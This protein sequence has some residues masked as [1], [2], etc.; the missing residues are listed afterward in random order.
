MEEEKTLNSMK[1]QRG[2]L[3][4][5]DQITVLHQKMIENRASYRQKLQSSQ[6]AQH[7]QA[8]LVQKLQ[9]KVLQYRNWCKELEKRLES[10]SDSHPHLRDHKVEQNL[11][12][13]LVHLEEEQQRCENLGRVN[14]LLRKHLDKANEVNGALQEDIN[15]LT[16]DWTRAKIELEHKESDWHKERELFEHY[17][18]SEHDRILGIWRQVVTL[19][20][21]FLEMKTATD[22]DLSELKADQVRLYGSILI[23]CFHV[24]SDAQFWETKHLED[25]ILRCQLQERR[26]LGIKLEKI[27]MEK[28]KCQQAKAIVALHVKEDFSKEDLQSR[29]LELTALLDESHKQN[30]EKEK[31][32]KALRETVEMLK[33]NNLKIN[34]DQ[35]PSKDISEEIF[36]LQHV[37]TEITQAL[38][39]ENNATIGI[40]QVEKY[41]D[42]CG[43]VEL[44]TGDSDG[45]LLLLR[46]V[47]ARRRN[48]V[49]QLRQQLLESQDSATALGKQQKQQE[50]QCSFLR[51]RLEQLEGERDTYA[52][53]LQ[54]LQSV[55]ETYRS[56]HETLDKSRMELQQQL[57][58]LEQEA[59]HLRQSNTELQLKGDMADGEKEEKQEE[60][61][62]LMREREYIQEDQNALEEKHS[63]LKNELIAMRESLEK[64]HLDG[65]L[66]KQEKYELALALEQAEESL[67]KLTGVHNRLK[68]ET[69]NLHD[70]VTKM[71]AL[72]EALALDKVSLNQL[73]LKLEQENQALLD[74]VDHMER[75]GASLQKQL[76]Q[77]ER[78]NEELSAEKF[79]LE[80]LLHKA[81]ELQ[82]SLQNE[83]R[84]LT[85]EKEEAN[86]KLSQVHHQN[87]IYHT[88]LEQANQELIHT[89]EML[90]KTSREKES[91]MREKT[92]LEVRL[93]VVERDRLTLT[94]QVSKFR[95]G[96]DLLESNFF[97]TQQQLSQLE[98]T[99]DQ[100]EMKIQTINQAKEVVQGEVKCLRA[101]LE[102]AKSK[103]EQEKEEKAQQLSQ[104]EQKYQET[105]RRC[106]TVH[107]EEMDT[108]SKKLGNE[109]ER[110]QIELEH[111]GKEKEEIE[112]V[113]ERKLLEL[114][115]KITEIQTHMEDELIKAE[116]A[117]QEA[118]LEKDNEKKLLREEI[119]QANEKLA[120]TSQ[121]L[122][123]LHQEMKKLEKRE[124]NKVQ[125]LEA[126][127]KDTTNTMKTL[128]IKQNEE[129]K[130][131]KEEINLLLNQ[132]NSLQNQIQELEFQLLAAKDSCKLFNQEAEQ[133]LREK[134]ELSERKEL[135]VSQLQKVLETERKQKEELEQRNTELTAMLQSQWE[136]EKHLNNK[137]LRKKEE[138]EHQ[139]TTVQALERKQSQWEKVELQNSELQRQWEEAKS[140]IKLLQSQK[141]D[142]ELQNRNLRQQKEEV[143]LKNAKLKAVLQRQQEEAEHESALLQSHWEEAQK[144]CSEL[145][146]WKEKVEYQNAEFQALLH[147]R[148][149]EMESKDT[150]MKKEQNQNLELKA[151]L[152]TLEHERASLILSLEEKEFR[153]KKLQE[154]DDAHQDEITKLNSALQQ[155]EKMLAEH[156]QEVQELISQMESLKQMM[157]QKEAT[158]IAHGEQLTQD[159]EVSHANEQHAKDTIQKLE[160][161]VSQLRLSLCSTESRAEALASECQRVCSVHWEA[162]AQLIKLHSVLHYMLCNSP[163]PKL[164]GQGD[165]NILSTSFLNREQD[166]M[167][168]LAFSQPKDCSTELTAERVAEA[169]QDWRQDLW[170]AHLQLDEARKNSEKLKQELSEKETERIRINAKAE[171][172]E[173]WL[174]QCQEEKCVAEGRRSSLESALKLEVIAF[175]EENVILH[176]KVTSL[177]TKLEKTEKQ[178]KGLANER[179]TLQMTKEKLTQELQLLQESVK[180]SEHRASAMEKM[181]ESLKQELQTAL[182][183]LR[184]KHEEIETHQERFVALQKEVE[185]GK[186]LQEIV[187]QLNLTLEKRNEE[188]KDQLQQ[189][190]DL[191]NHKEKQ[192]AALE[193]LTKNLEHRS[194]EIDSQ[195]MQIEEMT[196]QDKMQKA[197][198][199]KLNLDLEETVQTLKSQQEKLQKLQELSEGQKTIIESLSLNLEEKIKEAKIKEEKIQIIEH[200]E[201][202][203][204]GTLLKDLDDLKIKMNEKGWEL[205]SQKKLLQEWE[206]QG[207]KREK[208]LCTSLE[209]MKAIIK[210]KERE[211]DSQREQISIFQQLEAQR[212]EHLSELSEKQKQMTLTLTQ[213]EQELKAQ[214]N[215]MKEEME[216]ERMAFH[217]HRAKSQATLEEKNRD[218]EFQRKHEEELKSQIRVLLEDIQY[219]SGVLKER[220]G[221]ADFPDEQINQLKKQKLQETTF[222]MLGQLKIF[223]KRWQ[224]E[225]ESLKEQ[226]EKNTEENVRVIKGLQAELQQA[227]QALKN[228]ELQIK[229]LKEKSL[230]Q[231]QQ[232]E[233]QT[234]FI[235]DKLHLTRSSLHDKEKETKSLQTRIK[236]LSKKKEEVQHA[237]LSLQ[238]DLDRINQLNAEREEELLKQAEQ[239]SKYQAKVEATQ[240][241]QKSKKDLL[242]YQNKNEQEHEKHLREQEELLDQKNKEINDQYEGN[243]KPVKDESE[244]QQEHRQLIQKKDDEIKLQKGKIE[245]LEESLKDKGRELL[246]YSDQIKQIMSALRLHDNK[247]YNFHSCIEKIFMWKEEELAKSKVIKQ[248]D[249]CLQWQKEKIEH[250]ENEKM[251]S[252]QELNHMIAVLKQTES[253]EIEW[254]QKAQKL[255]LTLAR[256]EEAMRI[257]KE[258]IAVTQSMVSE[259]DMDR[260]HLQEQLDTAFKTLKEA[261]FI[262]ETVVGVSD[263]LCSENDIPGVQHNEDEK[264]LKKEGQLTWTAEKRLLYRPLQLLQQAVVRLEKDKHGLEK[265]N[266]QLR[267][268]LQEVEHERRK[269]K[270]SH[271]DFSL[272][273]EY[274]QADSGSQKV[275][276]ISKKETQVLQK[277][278]AELQKQVFVLQSQLSLERK[279]KQNYIINCTKT[280]QELSDLHQEL[281]NSLAVVARKPEATVLESET[282]KLDETLNN[283]FTLRVVGS[284]SVLSGKHLPSSTPKSVHQKPTR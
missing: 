120:N 145:Q 35:I 179:G 128:T 54:H 96:K 3:L 1:T 262:I 241:E 48:Q 197:D 167:K 101:E 86:E 266:A 68:A 196:M 36:S 131:L 281:V 231:I 41:A 163:E 148:Q 142:T 277:Q 157:V 85:G 190:R 40:R 9:A 104:I 211:I 183:S 80:Q 78:T 53:Q 7:R 278:L 93:K 5:D 199:K 233:A 217:E 234:K 55:L 239:I 10:N 130:S 141:R 227:K 237:V 178:R 164:R 176:E 56:D 122:E 63:L 92:A 114:Q 26:Q 31:T 4:P 158:L 185:V 14:I 257:L 175:K 177:E 112:S 129:I 243:K 146:N 51:D 152:K 230:Q 248:K 138:V 135:E 113:Y 226:H 151:T 224:Q 184:N 44:N 84:V 100:L 198:L 19:H 273:F 216:I 154:R 46:D 159:L 103:V 72:N 33:A 30:E 168:E 259:R 74:K 6:E 123:C 64:S 58:I 102:A 24:S 229:Y 82:E 165:K 235:L 271:G 20:R 260:F 59:Q 202:A 209:H 38:I 98:V 187:D 282:R 171:E 107:K 162:Q 253:G 240:R 12:N 42:P 210:D 264:A 250:L 49:E 204:I 247:D 150:S 218:L 180:A 254:K 39:S 97:Q 108:L 29:V 236:E 127:L 255:D 43:I 156:K 13:I 161:E 61:E 90:S 258:E 228:G 106:Y 147:N 136:T 265:H 99:R 32:V 213:R 81:E 76:N 15:K 267:D 8:I 149:E 245:Q 95:S 140:Q 160:A 174:S 117:K 280:N 132:Q 166:N 18:Q 206:E 119:F 244:E 60:L 37:L 88:S 139:Q 283:S 232:Q 89:G 170:R 87:E 272:S 91:L 256:S 222:D 261:R 144:R 192:K 111:I 66:M 34:C 263:L 28:E 246:T 45:T 47:L 269:L 126:E 193:H 242:Q 65:E 27:D 69:A 188:I 215:K 276:S 21:H 223:F 189:I 116:N 252:R 251:I 50:D 191:E 67:A 70:T 182:S 275:L 225:T 220:D 73:I 203:Q 194:K 200:N 11:E 214:E 208:A 279:Q 172:L 79:R 238:Q 109:R 207:E 221:N 181:N 121:Q 62:R 125:L 124:Q 2:I 134:Q 118:L 274:S 143:E 155:A 270:K 169:L 110:R 75:S 249:R 186:A 105:L 205:A 201:S 212:E 52:S 25:S 219:S 173:K 16:D 57:E 23:N 94:E 71:S 284:D 77:T 22:R 268:A 133:H 17:R 153:L 195:K 137:L 115:Q 83:L